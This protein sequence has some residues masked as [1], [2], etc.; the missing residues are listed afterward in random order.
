MNHWKVRDLL[1][2]LGMGLIL[3][4]VLVAFAGRRPLAREEIIKQA[5]AVGM[6]F[7]QEVR[8][9]EEEPPREEQQAGEEALLPPG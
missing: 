2:G 4:A 5:R 9:S 8:L 6:V 7:P 1:T 3:A